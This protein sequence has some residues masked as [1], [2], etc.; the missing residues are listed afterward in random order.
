MLSVLCSDN[1]TG[2]DDWDKVGMIEAG[3]QLK[4][5]VFERKIE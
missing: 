5:E 1:S 3:L 4:V 2:V